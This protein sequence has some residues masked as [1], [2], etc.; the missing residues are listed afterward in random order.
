MGRPRVFIGSSTEGKR[1]A[2]GLNRLLSED[3]E[4]RLWD[5]GLFLPGRFPI[6]ELERQLRACD[7]AILI[8]TPD[9]EV[10]KRSETALVMRDNV[11]FEV[12]LF[13][14]ALGRRRV[15]LITPDQP[16]VNI[17]SDLAGIG[18]GE[19]DRAR[20]IRR[21]D[22]EIIASIQIAADDARDA[23]LQEWGRMQL[24]EEDRRRRIQ[25]SQRG[26]AIQR[27]YG[28]AIR[29]RDAILA[30]QRDSFKDIL[31][32]QTLESMRKTAVDKVIQ[33]AESFRPDAEISGAVEELDNLRDA[34]VAAISD[35]P[36]PRAAFD[37]R[38][39]AG[40]ALSVAVAAAMAHLIQS[41]AKEAAGATAKRKA[42][43]QYDKLLHL[44]TNWWEAH[45]PPL[46]EATDRM[47]DA[48]FRAS[49]QLGVDSV[50][51]M[52]D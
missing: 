34:T 25:A 23:I 8:A 40:A 44:Y 33:T 7:F 14:G 17:P 32:D 49:T 43:P 5:Q 36:D 28:V 13:A 2:R 46:Q 26:Q 3:C 31:A 50:N 11:L 51:S 47:R 52:L 15:L 22:S 16:T 1:L 9:D 18:C 35:F 24:A 6:E 20:S 37:P 10:T 45:M 48:L 21:E 12:G 27:L 4:I 41:D 39:A 38:E 42:K 29:L 19:Y 30:I